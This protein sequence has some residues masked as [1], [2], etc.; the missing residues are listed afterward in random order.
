[1]FYTDKFL[2]E[3]VLVVGRWLKMACCGIFFFSLSF[4]SNSM[5]SLLNNIYSSSELFC[6]CPFHIPIP[7][8]FKCITE[9]SWEMV[10]SKG[11]SIRPN[12]YMYF[13]QFR[14]SKNM[15]PTVKEIV[16]CRIQQ[17]FFPDLFKRLQSLMKQH[18]SSLTNTYLLD[19]Q[20]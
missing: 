11:F 15:K 10:I 18:T 4:L 17:L 19:G 2:R 14:S 5:S 13:L 6:S 9:I 8:Y 16:A 12:S 1:M 20:T 7:T 3:K